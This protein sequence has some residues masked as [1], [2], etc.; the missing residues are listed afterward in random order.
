VIKDFER[1]IDTIELTGFG[2]ASVTEALSFATEIDEDVVFD[3]GGGDTLIVEDT[4]K[5]YL[6]NDLAI[7][8]RSKRTASLCNVGADIG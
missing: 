2:G 6:T 4:A 1:N 8:D 3:F 7:D 5:S